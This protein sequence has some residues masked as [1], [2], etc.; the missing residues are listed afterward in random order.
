MPLLIEFATGGCDCTKVDSYP[1]TAVP[2][3]GKGAIKIT[4]DTTEKDLGPAKG[5]ANV[6]ANTDPIV[7]EIKV[8]ATVEK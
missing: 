8:S 4:F 5:D 2:V 7:S 3:G 6:I 1:K